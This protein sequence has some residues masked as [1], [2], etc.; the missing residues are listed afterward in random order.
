MRNLE[1]LYADQGKYSEAEPL[2]QDSLT[3]R[4]QWLGNAHPN[5]AGGVQPRVVVP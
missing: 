5:V 1:T 4:E 3:I 2:F